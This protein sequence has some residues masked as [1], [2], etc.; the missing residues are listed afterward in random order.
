[1]RVISFSIKTSS[2]VNLFCEF[3]VLKYCCEFEILWKFFFSSVNCIQLLKMC[4]VNSCCC[5]NLRTGSLII[6]WL[7]AIGSLLQIFGKQS[8]NSYEGPIQ[9]VVGLV[10]YAALLYGIYARRPTWMLLAIILSTIK[11]VIAVILGVVAI[12]AIASYPYDDQHPKENRTTGIAILAVIY[13]FVLGLGIYFT[14]VL[15][16]FYKELKE[17]PGNPSYA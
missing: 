3:S 1:M 2:G 12:V 17:N 7:C 15:Y 13:A 5:F 6:G 4:K 11:I 16:S 9:G 14:S 10:I 8:G